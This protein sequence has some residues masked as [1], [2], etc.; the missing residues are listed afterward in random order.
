MCNEYDKNVLRLLRVQEME[1]HPTNFLCVQQF[2]IFHS[3]HC[4]SIS[5]ILT[6]KC[7]QYFDVLDMQYIW[8]LFSNCCVQQQ[9]MYSQMM[10]QKGPK[11]VGV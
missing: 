3:V 9:L 6:D 7:T 5:T 2:Y 8:I 1:I 11:L 10:G 4:N